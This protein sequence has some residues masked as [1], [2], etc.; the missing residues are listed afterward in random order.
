MFDYIT[1][2]LW[3][4]FSW[5]SFLVGVVTVGTYLVMLAYQY[6]LPT[7]DL[8]KKYRGAEW[9][10]VTGASSGIGKAICEQL[11]SQQINCV[12][13]ALKDEMLATT[14]AELRSKN[15][16]LKF[17]EVGCNLGGAHTDYMPAII[18]ATDDIDVRIVFNNA[19]FILPGFTPD[20]DVERVRT[21][22]NCNL[23]AAIEIAHHFARR[24][25][26]RNL[27]GFIGF[28]SSA[29]AYFPGPTATL[30]STTKAAVTNFAATLSGEVRDAGIDVSVVHPSP[31]ATNFYANSAGMSSLETARK[32]AVGPAV[33]SDCF[34]RAAGRV[35]IYD[36]GTTT[37]IFRV[38]TK[39][40]D[41]AFFHEIVSRVGYIF[42]QDHKVLVSKSKVRA[43]LNKKDN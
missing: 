41:F 42:N 15:P 13:V 30:Y 20:T 35:V 7:Q 8:K 6:L 38:V 23:V 40:I 39:L 19:G 4:F 5:T 25:L 43:T 12:L 17:R 36:Q 18:E 37:H 28:T 27:T 1:A 14:V 9:A 26:A 11:A 31:V 29:G 33:I 3:F 32:V 24:M 2:I 21:N 22:L 10:L 16:A 34:F